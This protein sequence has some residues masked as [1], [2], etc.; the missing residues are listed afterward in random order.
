MANQSEDEM[1]LTQSQF[2]KDDDNAAAAAAAA[3]DDDDFLFRFA[4]PLTEEDIERKLSRCVPRTTRYKNDWA[5]GVFR[6]WQEERRTRSMDA[7]IALSSSVLTEDLLDM[8]AKDI[9]TALKYFLFEARKV[10]GTCYPAVTVYGLFTAIASHLKANKSP[11]NLMEGEE[12]QDSR[13]ALDACMRERSTAGLGADVRKPTE[14]ITR[15][16]EN[17]LWEKGALGEGTPQKL[18]DTVLYLT[19]LNFALRGGKEHR[20][21]RLHQQPQITG[22]HTDQNGRRYLQYVEDVSKTNAGGVKDRKLQKKKVRAYENTKNPERCYV[23]LFM[24][25]KSL[26]LPSS[27]RANAFYFT[28]MKKPKDGKWYLESPMGHNTIQT[29]VKRICAE[30]GIEGR[31]TNHSLRCTA[32]TRLY[33]ANISEQ[34]ICEQT[35]HKSE[36]VRVYKRTSDQ[37]QAMASDVL[38]CSAPKKTQTSATVS[39][40]T[41]EGD[42]GTTQTVAHGSVTMTFNFN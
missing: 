18:L 15:D 38:S 17:T 34:Q 12:F 31:K 10:D 16:E 39:V 30:A 22:P 23:R 14:V 42:S 25:Y 32:A 6:R 37:Q 1:F 4:A 8:T 24:K 26:C 13:Q 36:A 41:S 11:Y 29:T 7:N 21:L 33:E 9:N 5:K 28:P 19:G 2:K 27:T 40:P 20:S 3:D 35:G